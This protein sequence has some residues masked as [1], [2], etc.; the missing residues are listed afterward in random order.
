MVTFD[1][2]GFA[3][4]GW[5]EAGFH[6]EAADPEVSCHCLQGLERQGVNISDNALVRHNLVVFRNGDSAMQVSKGFHLPM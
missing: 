1:F 5:R 2:G 6:T 4:R 3:C